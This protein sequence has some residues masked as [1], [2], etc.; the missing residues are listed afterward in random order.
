MKHII[1][2]LFIGIFLVSCAKTENSIQKDPFNEPLIK[3]M[4]TNVFYPGSSL[5]NNNPDFTFNF[6]Y[7]TY[8][9]LIKKI[10]GDLTIPI[11]SGNVKV[12]TDKIYT[13]LVY[14]GQNVTVEDFS[15]SADFSAVLNTK[16][17]TL[18]DLNQIEKKEIPNEN[19]YLLKKQTFNYSDKHITE[20]KTFF[21]NLPYV[22]TDLNSFILTYVEKFYY[23]INGNLIRS[24][25]FRQQ[26]G[27]NK[28]ERIIRTF[29]DYDNSINPFKRLQLLDE[30]FYRSLSKNNY[31]KYT[32]IHYY[33]EILGSAST[34]TWSFNYDGKG[35]IIIF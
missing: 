28:G 19:N 25:Y 17:F 23:D 13:T 20:I 31:R 24:E 26:N 34:T 3:K 12:F 8:S 32:E 33:N 29:E 11:S 10:G 22:S 35:Q 14:S 15:S 5:Y 9:R 30:F 6:E 21:P 27:I 1:K 7:D 4:R 16:Y 18:N 2:F